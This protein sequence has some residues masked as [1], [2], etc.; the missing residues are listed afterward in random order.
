MVF[1]EKHNTSNI[2]SIVIDNFFVSGGIFMVSLFSISISAFL[3][4]RPHCS[5]AS[6]FGVSIEELPLWILLFS[7]CSPCDNM[8]HEELVLLL[9]TGN[10]RGNYFGRYFGATCVLR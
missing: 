8:M 6:M 2:F 7:G 4:R 3:H 5:D 1:D 9:L 10:Y